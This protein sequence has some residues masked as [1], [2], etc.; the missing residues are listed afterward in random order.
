LKRALQG[1]NVEAQIQW[2]TTQPEGHEV[3]VVINAT[4]LRDA[5]GRIS[6]AVAWFRDITE[7]REQQVRL[8]DSEA[9]HRR[10]SMLLSRVIEGLDEGVIVYDKDGK[11]LF[12]NTFSRIFLGAGPDG[13]ARERLATEYSQYDSK[14]N[15]LL[16][17][18]EHAGA[19]AMGGTAVFDLETIVRAKHLTEDIVM[20]QNAVP[21]VN[22]DGDIEG[23]ILWFRDVTEERKAEKEK[24]ETAAKLAQA[25]KMEAVGQL[26]RSSRSN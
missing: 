18:E 23:S 3:L 21:L 26:I 13:I 16:A 1:E 4:P 8:A 14:T 10:Q 7:S 15:R 19:I 9:R 12:S 6:G 20:L 5:S 11:V 17:A 24:A 2:I 25:Q 22:D